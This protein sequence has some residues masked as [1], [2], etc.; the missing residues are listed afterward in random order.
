M[1]EKWPL[2]C[3]ETTGE[4]SKARNPGNWETSKPKRTAK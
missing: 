2:Q 4:R 1:K 3:K